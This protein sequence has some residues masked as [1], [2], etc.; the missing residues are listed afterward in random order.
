MAPKSHPLAAVVEGKGCVG[1]DMEKPPF[2][3]LWKVIDLILYIFSCG[4]SVKVKINRGN[5]K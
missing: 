5:F 1:Y 2:L 3:L 4:G